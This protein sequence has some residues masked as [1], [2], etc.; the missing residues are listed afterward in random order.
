MSVKQNR[1]NNQPSLELRPFDR[2]TLGL[3]G[4]GVIFASLGLDEAVYRLA[5]FDF[6]GNRPSSNRN[7]VRAGV[8]LDDHEGR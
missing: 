5:F 1:G 8:R 2:L 3:I 7:V 6:E 4:L